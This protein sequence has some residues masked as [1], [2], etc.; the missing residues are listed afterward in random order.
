MRR[1]ISSR[2]RPGFL[3]AALGG[4]F[5]A[6]PAAAEVISAGDHG[7]EVRQSVNLVVPAENAF[8]AIADVGAW[9]NPEHS[10]SGKSENLSL[11]PRA[12]GCFCEQL[13]GG[14]LEHLRVA[15]VE[16]GK[17]M[18]LTG[19]LGP[20]L[21]EAVAGVMDL[22]VETIAGGSRVT[23]S[24]KAAGFASGGAANMAPLVDKVLADQMKRYRAYAAGRPQIR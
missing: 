18:V 13:P 24:Y 19:A 2:F 1:L 16:P 14:P 9:W 11:E 20:L 7:F 4:A 6:S 17:R 12:G 22:K 23:M 21:F 8:A 5:A 10:Y 3:I 15:Y